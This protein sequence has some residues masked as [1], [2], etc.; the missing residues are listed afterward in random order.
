MENVK[1]QASVM[2]YFIDTTFDGAVRSYYISRFYFVDEK[3]I[4]MKWISDK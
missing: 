3:H 2:K 4:L 1:C